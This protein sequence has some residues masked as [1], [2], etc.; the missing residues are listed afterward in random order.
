MVHL[1]RDFPMILFFALVEIH[2]RGGLKLFYWLSLCLFFF[3]NF[4]FSSVLSHVHNVVLN[5]RRNMEPD[6]KPD[7]AQDN[8]RDANMV[9]SIQ[10]ACRHIP[11]IHSKVDNSKKDNNKLVYNKQVRNSI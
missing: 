6:N 10:V 11:V 1:N 3:Q 8:G 2:H 5:H 7:M 4:F 9:D